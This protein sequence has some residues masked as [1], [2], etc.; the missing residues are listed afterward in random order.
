MKHLISIFLNSSLGKIHKTVTKNT[1]GTRYF[2][3]VGILVEPRMKFTDHTLHLKRSIQPTIH[4]W[5][6][7]YPTVSQNEWQ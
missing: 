7:S 6:M 3:R 5:S 2:L 1:N 4:E